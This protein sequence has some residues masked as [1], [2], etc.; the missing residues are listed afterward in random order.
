MKANKLFNY[1][2]KKETLIVNVF[3]EAQNNIKDLILEYK[4]VEDQTKNDYNDES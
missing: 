3:I 2:F 4:V 1:K